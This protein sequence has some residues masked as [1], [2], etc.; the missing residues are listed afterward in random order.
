MDSDSDLPALMSRY[1]QGDAS[2]ATALV[3]RLSP[4]MHRF[5]LMKFVSRRHA[6]D[7]L[8]ETWLR[9]HEVRHTYRP[10]E[11]VLPWLYAIARNIRVDHYR[12]A[13][14]TEQREEQLESGHDLPAAPV[15]NSSNTPD[16]EALLGELPE[17]QREVV[18]MLKL[19]DMSLDEVARA[20]SSTVGSVKQ[21]AHR[22]YE[23]LRTVLAGTGWPRGKGVLRERSGD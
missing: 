12:K 4:R 2:A 10:D 1:Q 5:F 21:K 3:N 23:K 22:A 6:D 14:R 20:T 17:S 7:L 8:Q 9:I 16:L 11:P 13:H 18:A 15:E 19:C